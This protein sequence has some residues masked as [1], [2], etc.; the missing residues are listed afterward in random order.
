MLE[1]LQF[2]FT[3]GYTYFGTLLLI[4]TIGY[5]VFICLHPKFDELPMECEDEDK[6]DK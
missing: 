4:I 5:I 3:S 2:I 6:T 1:T